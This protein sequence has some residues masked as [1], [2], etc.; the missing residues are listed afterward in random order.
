MFFLWC[1]IRHI[2]PTKE[3]P[4]WILKIHKKI[5]KKLD[6]DGTEFP[7]QGKDFGKI[8]VENNI[9]SNVFGYENVLIFPIYISD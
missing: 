9:C 6:S 4:E 1:H 5:V 8:E 2:N 3:H 7:L